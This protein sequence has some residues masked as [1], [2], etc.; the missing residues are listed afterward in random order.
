MF[1]LCVDENFRALNLVLNFVLLLA[2][3]PQYLVVHLDIDGTI[4]LQVLITRYR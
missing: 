3:V 4:K 1:F 2:I